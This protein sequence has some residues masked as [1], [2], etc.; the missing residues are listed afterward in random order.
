MISTITAGG[1]YGVEAYLVQVEVDISTGLPGFSMVGSLNGEVREARE[2]VQV[3]LRNVG[4]DQP[5]MKITVNLAPADIRKEGTAYDLPIAV[6]ILQSY[7]YF[8]PADTEGIL[9]A[10]ELGLSGEIKGVR[11]ILPIVREAAK[12]G[13]KCC[14]VPMENASEGAVI[15]G[16]EVRGAKDFKQIV[17]FLQA[18]ASVRNEILPVVEIDRESYFAQAVVEA[19]LDFSDVHGQEGAKRAAEIAAA[20]FHNLMMIGPPGAGKSMIAKR[21]PGILPPLSIEE[22]MEVS[23]I[24]SVAGKLQETQ[25]LLVKR[26]FQSPHHSITQAALMGGSIVP[27]PGVISLAHRGVLFLDEL[28]EFARMTLDSLRQPL[29]DQKV[30]VS[31]VYGNFSYPAGFMLVCAMNPCVCGYYPDKNRCTCTEPEVRKYLGKISG[32][33]LDRID[34]C[35][36]ILPINVSQLNGSVGESSEVIR[37]RVMAARKIQEERKQTNATITV[38]DMDRIC[39][40]GKKQRRLMEQAYETMHLSARGYHRTLRVARTIADLANE[41]QILEEH[42]MEALCFRM[43]DNTYWRRRNDAHDRTGV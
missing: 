43:A 23:S 14:I 13:I 26:P 1:L 4:F 42:L 5:P 37:R 29:E 40:L 10:G 12:K 19:E 31:R 20:G 17:R 38:S 33:I 2:R 28:P 22:S 36:E 25:P 30:Q 24:Y 15:P 6:G 11:G 34:L 39:Y 32:P 27:K 21:I 9:F 8:K 3:A 35:V 41:E 7:G 18:K 16:I